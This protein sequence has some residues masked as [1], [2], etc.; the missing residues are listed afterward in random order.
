MGLGLLFEFSQEILDGQFPSFA[1]LGEGHA[2]KNGLTAGGV[3]RRNRFREADFIQPDHVLGESIEMEGVRHAREA[4]CFEVN[5]Q[6]L[7]LGGDGRLAAVRQ[8]EIAETGRV[9]LAVFRMGPVKYFL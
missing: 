7:P 8:H 9:E 2:G 6:I 5:D 4:G 1:G 3:D